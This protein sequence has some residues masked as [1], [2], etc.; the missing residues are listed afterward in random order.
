[1]AQEV[2]VPDWCWPLGGKQVSLVS[3][4]L[5]YCRAGA[6]LAASAREYVYL[7]RAYGEGGAGILYAGCDSALRQLAAS[8][9]SQSVL[10]L[11]CLR[12]HR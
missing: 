9:F 4:A 3:R 1:M 5:S 12:C 2:G 7:R 6:L 8:P 10:L 11:S